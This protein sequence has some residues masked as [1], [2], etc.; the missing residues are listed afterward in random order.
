[1]TTRAQSEFAFGLNGAIDANHAKSPVT[2]FREV[3]GGLALHHV[4]E[5]LPVCSDRHQRDHERRARGW[6]TS[7]G[8]T[9]GEPLRHRQQPVEPPH[10]VARKTSTPPA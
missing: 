7:F 8:R 6:Y 9:V 1:V 4:L 2:A 3:P 10:W 5:T